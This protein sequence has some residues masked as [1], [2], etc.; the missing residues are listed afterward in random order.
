MLLSYSSS[1]CQNDSIPLLYGD[2]VRNVVTIDIDYI[3]KANEKLIAHK[4]CPLIINQKD[5]IINEY[6][7]LI[8]IYKVNEIKYNKLKNK[9]KIYSVVTISSLIIA[10]IS[11]FVK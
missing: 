7:K 2:T 10:L 1:W 5:S 3:R 8:D 6:E 4:Y 11:I 9:N